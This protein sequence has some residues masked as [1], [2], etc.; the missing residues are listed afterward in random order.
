MDVKTTILHF[1]HCL[2]TK[3]NQT[4]DISL[5][6]NRSD[7]TTSEAKITPTSE[8]PRQ[9][10]NQNVGLRFICT[11]KYTIRL[12]PSIIHTN[13]IH[14]KSVVCKEKKVN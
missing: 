13:G 14:Q 2:K 7:V 9:H 3:K 1:Q 4:C 5:N 6:N 10:N 12:F 11:Y 8:T